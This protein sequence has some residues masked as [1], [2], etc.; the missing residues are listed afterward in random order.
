V[1]WARPYMGHETLFGQLAVTGD[2]WWM[3]RWDLGECQEWGRDSAQVGG[4]HALSMVRIPPC[5]ALRH[6][7]ITPRRVVA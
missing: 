6:G 5:A 2:S 1:V 4:C 3:E 7:V